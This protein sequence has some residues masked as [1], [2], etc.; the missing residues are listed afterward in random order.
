EYP[1]PFIPFPQP[2]HSRGEALGATP[3]PPNPKRGSRSS[4]LLEF[5]RTTD[6]ADSTDC[7]AWYCSR[8]KRKSRLQREPNGESGCT[9]GQRLFAIASLHCPLG[10]VSTQ[11]L[12]RGPSEK[13]PPNIIMRSFTLSKPPLF[14]R[15]ACTGIGPGIDSLVHADEP[16][17]P[18]AC[19]STQVSLTAPFLALPPK[20][21][22]VLVSGS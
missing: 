21:V 3:P 15:V 22:I 20:I 13:L 5:F 8:S 17:I 9:R 10:S 12:Q 4:R 14:Q 11:V 1:R 19:E 6:F 16:P 18:L 7:D 2:I